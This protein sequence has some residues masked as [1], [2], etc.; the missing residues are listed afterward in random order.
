MTNLTTRI[1]AT[2]LIRLVSAVA[3]GLLFVFNTSLAVGSATMSG[4][5]VDA[6]GK[7]VRGAIVKVAIG[8]KSISRYTD[9]QGKYRVTGLAAGQASVTAWAFGFSEQS[10]TAGGD[11]LN[12]TLAAAKQPLDYN[13]AELRYLIPETNEPEK[14]VY[15][16]CMACHG[17]E[18]IIARAGMPAAAWEGFLPYMSVHRWGFSFIDENFAAA[19]AGPVA[20][21]FGPDGLFGP[22][23]K[24]DFSKIKGS[25]LSDAALKATITEYDIPSKGAQPHT[26]RVDPRNGTVWF[27]DFD[28]ASNNIFRF[29]PVTEVFKSY[30][31]PVPDA[32]GHTGTILKDGSYL[33]GLGREGSP[34]KLVMARPDGSV[35]TVSWVGKLQSSRVVESDPAHNNVV[36]VMAGPETWRFNLKTGERTAY[37]NPPVPKDFAKPGDRP[38]I[39]GVDGYDVAVDSKGIPW[40]TQFNAG[41]IFKI[42]P[43]TGAT[44]SYHTPEME[45]ARGIAVDAHD[46]I[47]FADFFGHK[48]GMLDQKTGTVKFFQPP[49]RYASPYGI[50][51][52]RIR[53]YIWYAD[54][55]PNNVV[56]FDPRTGQFIE[57]PI[58]T[59]NAAVRFLGI[60][61]QGRAWYGGYWNQK[62]GVVDPGDGNIRLSSAK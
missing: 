42:D 34:I 32:A 36:W 60:D 30:P 59:K 46:N 24:P 13:A 4:T 17:F 58:P 5:V 22:N 25:P 35:K 16:A 56:R 21:V 12:F 43:A 14:Q 8:N 52:D 2:R 11:E 3:L 31:I 53:G 1:L 41:V 23:A 51:I 7:P 39:D 9:A 27:A 19:I 49:T 62:L 47:W 26:V 37:H 33:V 50:T 48:L 29:D 28:A 57:Y 38:Y 18:N 61:P 55:A 44:K 54:T 6:A 15:Y 10:E 45:S 20:Q 40:V